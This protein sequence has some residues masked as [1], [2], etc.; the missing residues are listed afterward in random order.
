[1]PRINLNSFPLH[2]AASS[3]CLRPTSLR[4]PNLRPIAHAVVMALMMCPLESFAQDSESVPRS[5]EE[6]PVEIEFN[7]AFLPMAPGGKPL[8]VSQFAKGNPVYP[9]KYMLRLLVNDNP[10][11]KLELVFSATHDPLHAKPCFDRTLL[12]QMGVDFSKL[13]PQQV[14]DIDSPGACRGLSDLIPEASV[15]FD[16]SEQQ[17]HV[18]IPQAFMRRASQGYVDPSLWDRGVNA[19]LLMLVVEPMF[20]ID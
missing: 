6:V 5:E 20:P 12:Q 18:V 13:S 14:A 16:S 2:R 19:G 17:L 7:N 10:I 11:G 4:S 3:I 8:D 1:M 9:G 15:D